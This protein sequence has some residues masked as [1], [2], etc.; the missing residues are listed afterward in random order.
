MVLPW[1]RNGVELGPTV[2]LTL[3]SPWTLP[4]GPLE[5]KIRWSTFSQVFSLRGP[6]KTT[7]LNTFV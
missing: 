2:H 7:L 3:A 5:R 4:E 1:P 6:F